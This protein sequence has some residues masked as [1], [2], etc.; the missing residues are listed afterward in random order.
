MRPFGRRARP[1][2]R[3]DVTGRAAAA[4]P[5]QGDMSVKTRNM[6]TPQGR[7]QQEH[8]PFIRAAARAS[9]GG[10]ALSVVCG[11]LADAVEAAAAGDAKR[12]DEICRTISTGQYSTFAGRRPWPPESCA[13]LMALAAGIIAAESHYP[14]VLAEILRD[15][16]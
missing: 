6:H 3:P 8:D 11:A 12:L 16:R 15:M 13:T 10:V 1:G 14:K 9:Y 4:A 2:S 5:D 7:Y